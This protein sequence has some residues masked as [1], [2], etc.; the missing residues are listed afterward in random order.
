MRGTA[1]AGRN[2][3]RS[4]SERSDLASSAAGSDSGA[5]RLAVVRVLGRPTAKARSGMFAQFC[6]TSGGC[7]GKYEVKSGREG[8]FNDSVR[9]ESP[10]ILVSPSPKI[11]SVL[12]EDTAVE[13]EGLS[14]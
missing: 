8:G 1:V 2:G 11:L 6:W 14:C 10:I 5:N 7:V 12:A 9:I 13:L 4:P 3:I